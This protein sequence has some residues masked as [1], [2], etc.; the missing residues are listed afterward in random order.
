MTAPLVWGTTSEQANVFWLFLKMGRR[1]DESPHTIVRGPHPKLSLDWVQPGK[2]DWTEDDLEK[3]ITATSSRES[4]AKQP[5]MPRR[6]FSEK[7]QKTRFQGPPAKLKAP[8]HRSELPKS[9]W[10]WTLEVDVKGDGLRGPCWRKNAAERGRE[11]R[12]TVNFTR[13]RLQSRPSWM[14]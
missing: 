8:C 3:P 4:L 10:G 2:N 1:A 7:P 5:G 13:V 11:G 6:H 14:L 9:S 12:G